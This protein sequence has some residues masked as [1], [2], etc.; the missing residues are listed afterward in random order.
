M[1]LHNPLNFKLNVTGVSW[2]LYQPSLDEVKP[3][4]NTCEESQL[5]R[6]VHLKCGRHLQSSIGKC[7]QGDASLRYCQN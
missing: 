4:P 7:M 5:A 3:T 6:R 2:S 1:H